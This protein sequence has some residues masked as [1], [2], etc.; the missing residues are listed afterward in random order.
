MVYE[1]TECGV[2][3]KNGTPVHVFDNGRGY[4]IFSFGRTS[5]AVHRFVAEKH[6]P[7]PNN[8]PEVNHIDGN[9][10]NNHKT[11]LEWCT[12]SEN[13]KHAYDNGLR[14]ARGENNARSKITESVVHEICVLLK[15]GVKPSKIRD[16][17]YPYGA[18]RN[19]KRKTNWKHIADNYF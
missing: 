16:M 3:S 9:K 1:V 5:K 2:V 15:D 14:S 13:I 11:N 19:I 17:G 10:L 12:R 8:L 4:L 6:V 18:V 7:N